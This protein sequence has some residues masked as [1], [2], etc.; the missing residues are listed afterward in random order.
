M[1]EMSASLE[2]SPNLKVANLKVVEMSVSLENNPNLKVVA[3]RSH[4]E[5]WLQ[6]NLDV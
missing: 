5:E 3:R 4:L 6:E 2:N 1:E